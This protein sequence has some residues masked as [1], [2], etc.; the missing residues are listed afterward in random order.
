MRWIAAVL[1]TAF[2]AMSA[3]L[4][5]DTV[6]AFD[7]TN[8]KFPP[9]NTD[10]IFLADTRIVPWFMPGSTDLAEAVGEAMAPTR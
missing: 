5:P 8:Q 10:A 3:E 9:I 4:K 2:P 6:A 7:I 1:V